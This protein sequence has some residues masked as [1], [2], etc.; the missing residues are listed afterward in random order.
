MK[1]HKFVKFIFNGKAKT[2]LTF[3]KIY[4]IKTPIIKGYVHIANDK[5]EIFYYRED[6]FEAINTPLAELLYD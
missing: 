2:D 6:W 5:N 4:K 3:N 1:N